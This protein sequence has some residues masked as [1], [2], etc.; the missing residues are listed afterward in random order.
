M[1]VQ[2]PKLKAA[3][4]NL[5]WLVI[6]AA[7]IQTS[8]NETKTQ[9]SSQT[10]SEKKFTEIPGWTGIFQDTLPC[11]DCPGLLTWLE[12]KPDGYYKRI[13]T[14]IGE[15]DVFAHTRSTLSRWK[16]DAQNQVIVLDSSAELAYTAFTP[17]NDSTLTACDSKGKPLENAR[18]KIRRRKGGDGLP[19]N[20][21]G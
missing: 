9:S 19:A 17:L 20:K 7:A 2:H 10:A 13:S 18:W 14:R 6:L 5:L 11:P 8:C 1:Q 3:A 21:P 4:Q 16:F 15:A 12:I